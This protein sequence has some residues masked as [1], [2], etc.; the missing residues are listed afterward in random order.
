MS[1]ELLTSPRQVSPWEITILANEEDEWEKLEQIDENQ[2]Q[3]GQEEK[4]EKAA[5]KEKEKKEE[6]GGCLADQRPSSERIPA[7]AE[8]RILTRM[9]HLARQV[10]IRLR[11]LACGRVLSSAAAVGGTVHGAGALGSVP[12]LLHGNRVAHVPRAHHAAPRVPLLQARASSSSSSPSPSVP[13]C[14]MPRGLS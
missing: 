5:A 3:N 12:G 10:P 4:K 2:Q 11:A 14:A 8:T 9:Q 7:E 6:T 13:I 1:C